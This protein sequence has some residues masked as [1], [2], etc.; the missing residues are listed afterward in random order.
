MTTVNY[1]HGGDKEKR[2][3]ARLAAKAAAQLR[4]EQYQEKLAERRPV[5]PQTMQLLSM[6]MAL[7]VTDVGKQDQ[8]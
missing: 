3:I 7:G 5:S 6:A 2:K 8:R 4:R 1:N